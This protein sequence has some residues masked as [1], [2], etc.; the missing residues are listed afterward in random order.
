MSKAG[1]FVQQVAGQMNPVQG[2][3]AN[4]LAQPGFRG[5]SALGDEC[6]RS[7]NSFGVRAKNS[8][9][10]SSTM[11]GAKALGSKL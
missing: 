5:E 3:R 8:A 2:V 11:K 6:S 10:K 4:W 9:A 7:L 1:G